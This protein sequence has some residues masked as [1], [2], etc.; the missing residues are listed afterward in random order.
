MHFVA[1]PSREA[2][3]LRNLW[4][5]AEFDTGGSV[6]RASVE[7]L[8]AICL[9]SQPRALGGNFVAISQPPAMDVNRC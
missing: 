3:M 2:A 9:I 7:L 8:G 1:E 5:V 4:K 6:A